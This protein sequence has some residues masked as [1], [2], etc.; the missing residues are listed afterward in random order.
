MYSDE[1]IDRLYL[2]K[3]MHSGS[4]HLYGGFVDLITFSDEEAKKLFLELPMISQL[5]NVPC[6][7]GE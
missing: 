7:V 6:K 3:P 2:G 4:E 1:E 5:I